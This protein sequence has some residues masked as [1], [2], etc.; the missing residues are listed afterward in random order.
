MSRGNV[1]IRLACRRVWKVNFFVEIS[2]S[3]LIL[4][5]ATL[6]Q[7]SKQTP[8]LMRTLGYRSDSIVHTQGQCL[9]PTSSPIQS[10]HPDD[11]RRPLF[12]ESA[13][14]CT[15]PR[16]RPPRI[17]PLTDLGIHTAEL[18]HG[19]LRISPDRAVWDAQSYTNLIVFH[20][21]E[22]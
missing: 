2:S 17:P 11:P 21:V 13:G 12:P 3:Q 7:R 16:I 9:H 1:S 20:L 10:G 4:V 6:K 19:A 18:F 22:K 14:L 15:S 5:C 8:N